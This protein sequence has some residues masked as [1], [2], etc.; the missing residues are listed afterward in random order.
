MGGGLAHALDGLGKMNVALSQLGSQK[1][2]CE[3]VQQTYG[4]YSGMQGAM[5]AQCR[6]KASKCTS[7]C[8]EQLSSV[9]EAFESA[10]GVDPASKI[11]TMAMNLYPAQKSFL[12]NTEQR[13]SAISMVRLM[14]VM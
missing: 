10:C 11:A 7:G 9:I 3:A 14:T 6:R 5:A 2:T 4:M 8:N 1:R 12:M 13:F